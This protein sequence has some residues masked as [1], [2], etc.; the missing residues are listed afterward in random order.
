[1]SEPEN[2]SDEVVLYLKCTCKECGNHIEFPASSLRDTI[3]C[4]HCG[5]WTELVLPGQVV[6]Q[7][8][9]TNIAALALWI[10]LPIAVVAGLVIF[11][12]HKFSSKENSSQ[13]QKI[14]SAPA[15]PAM[16]VAAP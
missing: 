16:P 12:H 5:E 3:P 6:E 10:L 2:E 13:P 4:P 1:M 7:K 11:I 14:A 15:K 8:Q 9:D